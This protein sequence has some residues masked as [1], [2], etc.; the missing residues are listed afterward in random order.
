MNIVW[1]PLVA[2]LAIVGGAYGL[3]EFMDRRARPSFRIQMQRAIEQDSKENITR[4]FLKF[5]D[6]IFDPKTTGRPSILR[7]AI[8]SCTVLACFLLVAAAFWF[9]NE[10]NA[11]KALSNNDEWPGLTAILAAL[12]FAIGTNLIGDIFSLWETRIVIGRMAASPPKYHILFLV[13]DV[14]AT[15]LVYCMGLIVGALIGL[16]FEL[17]Q[18]QTTIQE[19]F[20]TDL[21]YRWTVGVLIETY[22]ELIVNKGIFFQTPNKSFDLFSIYFF[23]ALA[24][25]VW[26]WMFFAGLKL[27]KLFSFVMAW[28][29]RRLESE[30]EPVVAV[31]TVGGIVCGILVLVG[32]YAWV[33]TSLFTSTGNQ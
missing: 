1:E 18:N 17:L 22:T 27:C 19:I 13:F 11:F 7:S 5:F 6:R 28:Y 30:K 25:S 23:T 16:V 32:S 31:M 4:L 24:T 29:D 26:A 33:L 15:A 8:A 20:G 3:G 12:A 21:V 9:N 14:I 10:T 2:A